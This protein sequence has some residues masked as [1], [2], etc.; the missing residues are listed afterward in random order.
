MSAQAFE[1]AAWLGRTPTA[2][3]AA[4]HKAEALVYLDLSRHP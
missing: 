2:M 4:L 1:S 3:T